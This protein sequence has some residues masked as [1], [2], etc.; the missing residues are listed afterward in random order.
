MKNIVA[1]IFSAIATHAALAMDMRI[2]T[3]TGQ[4]VRATLTRYLTEGE[5]ELDIEI[6]RE[7]VLLKDLQCE[8]NEKKI[9]ARSR[10]KEMGDV[11]LTIV[12]PTSQT[13]T[14][15]CGI[16][17]YHSRTAA[18]LQINKGAMNPRFSLTCQMREVPGLYFGQSTNIVR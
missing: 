17:I 14:N 2:Y 16:V 1:L 9:I 13:T 6:G 15:D 11:T 5:D 18:T 3:C 12:Q 4:D 10:T 8:N 7:G